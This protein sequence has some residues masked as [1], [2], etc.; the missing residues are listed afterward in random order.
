VTD[1]A[2]VADLAGNTADASAEPEGTAKSIDELT[3]D[4]KLVYEALAPRK[5]QTPNQLSALAGLA[6]PLVLG[7]L[8]VLDLRGHV[9]HDG[10][11]GW[12]LA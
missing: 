1:A 6:L 4:Q 11:N 10:S 8:G 7:A 12:R 3:N 9:Q 2:E 5:Y